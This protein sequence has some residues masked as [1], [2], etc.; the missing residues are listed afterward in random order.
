MINSN[1]EELMPF[2]KEYVENGGVIT[3]MNT[4]SCRKYLQD[5]VGNRVEPEDVLW[6]FYDSK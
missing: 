3:P 6:L 5:K 4:E 1:R 2:Y